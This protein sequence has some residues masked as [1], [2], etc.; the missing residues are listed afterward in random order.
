MAKIKYKAAEQTIAGRHVVYAVPQTAGTLTFD[1]LIE[2]YVLDN[3]DY[4]D[5]C[6]CN[7]Q[8]WRGLADEWMINMDITKQKK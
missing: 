5:V 2:E 7:T 1:E 3:P 8:S 6:I 4:E